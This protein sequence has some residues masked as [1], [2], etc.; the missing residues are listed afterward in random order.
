MPQRP[1]ALPRS[2]GPEGRPQ[3]RPR[4]SDVPMQEAALL[5]R[6]PG[7]PSSTGRT[8]AA[9]AA[10]AVLDGAR[11]PQSLG[12]AAANGQPALDSRK[13]S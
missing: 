12:L 7:T 11:G 1:G 5:S 4:P 2:A 10:G 13:A 3:S 9:R 6:V 8:G